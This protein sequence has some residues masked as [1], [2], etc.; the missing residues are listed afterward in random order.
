MTVMQTV[1][2]P[3]HQRPPGLP[4]Y[5]IE[6]VDIQDGSVLFTLRREVL[7]SV[8]HLFQQA[9]THLPDEGP[10]TDLRQMGDLI[11]TAAKVIFD[12]ATP[13]EFEAGTVE[14]IIEVGETLESALQ[15]D[16]G[17]GVFLHCVDVVEGY[18]RLSLLSEE[19]LVAGKLLQGIF[20]FLDDG[21]GGVRSTPQSW[22]PLRSLGN[23]M[24]KI[25]GLFSGELSPQDFLHITDDMFDVN[26]DVV[27]EAA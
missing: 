13:A 20:V 16:C 5:V 26:G 7:W 24:L 11:E 22:A 4:K 17:E 15:T 8:A 12:I 23:K 6:T 14:Q 10:H 19:I 27:E 1:V 21:K 9:E 3:R 25:D 18:I 2:R